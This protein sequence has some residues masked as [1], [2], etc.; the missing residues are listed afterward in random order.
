MLTGEYDYS[1]TPEA[2]Q[3]TADLIPGAELT[4]MPGLGHFPMSENPALFRRYLLPV[5][6]K[7]DALPG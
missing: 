2:S 3:E 7:I 5:L 6:D 4:V 1:C